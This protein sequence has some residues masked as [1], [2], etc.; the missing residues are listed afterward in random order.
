MPSI[1]LVFS[2]PPDVN[3]RLYQLGLDAPVLTTAALQGLA[4]W[5]SC[6]LNHPPTYPGTVFW[7][8]TTRALREGLFDRG[9]ARKNE[10]NLPLVVNADETI[11]I[12]VASGDAATWKEDE[13]PCTRSAKGPK[14]AEAVRIN[15]QQSF[16]FIEPLP[17]IESINT[18]GRSTWLLLTYRDLKTRILRIELS[19]PIS[20]NEDGHVDEW[21]ERII[22]ASI[23]FADDPQLLDGNNAN[24]SPEITVNIRRLVS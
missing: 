14:T 20:M 22:L 8:E 16:E 17:V 23:P 12:A 6:T 3:Q 7:A 1:S 4:G 19:R 13:F 15:Q 9:F 10:A 11:A 21:A 24:Q 18:P 5:A 2:E